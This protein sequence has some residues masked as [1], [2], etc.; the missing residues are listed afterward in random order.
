MIIHAKFVGLRYFMYYYPATS[1]IVGSVFNFHVL[2]LVV[3]LSWLRFFAP[4]RYTDEA[5][6]YENSVSNG[7]DGSLFN[8]NKTKL[9]EDDTDEEKDDSGSR[10]SS[11]LVV[12][13]EDNAN[14]LDSEEDTL[15]KVSITCDDSKGDK[16]TK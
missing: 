14:Q 5:E 4:S 12:I 7:V 2:A 16:K 8:E 1:A 10:S 9:I 11:D 13:K 15:T 3:L 6:E